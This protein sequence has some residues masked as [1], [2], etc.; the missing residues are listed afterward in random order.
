MIRSKCSPGL[1]NDLAR[2]I[3]RRSPTEVVNWRLEKYNRD[4]STFFMGARVLSDRAT[5]IPDLPDSYIRQIVLRIKSQQS[6]FKMS[7]DE[8][9]ELSKKGVVEIPLSV[10]SPKIQ[11]CTEYLVIQKVRI[12]G[13]DRDWEIW[14]FVKPTTW[15][16]LDSPFFASGLTLKE[17]VQAMQDKIYGRM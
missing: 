3:R 2:R 13:R 15:E 10:T 1:A 12:G 9:E 6:T 16:D 7:K 11:D 5:T 17:R 4:P 8:T 14:G